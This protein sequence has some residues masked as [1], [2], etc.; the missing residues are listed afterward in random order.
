M[1]DAI[2]NN[3]RAPI[4]RSYA[5]Q[6]RAQLTS[7]W[8]E[9]LDRV[10]GLCEGQHR[11]RN[12]PPDG[13]T[14]GPPTPEPRSPTETERI[15]AEPR[16]PP[17]GDTRRAASDN[18]AEVVRQFYHAWAS[19]KFPTGLLDA[20]VEYINPI[21]A[22]ERRVRPGIDSFSEAIRAVLNGWEWWK[23]E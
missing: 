5:E 17:H 21:G 14:T 11:A 9:A 12:V 15:C 8:S 19:D 1:T 20:D 23:M 4:A 18:S 22:I 16:E 3:R 6:R 13:G 10:K 7:F 2:T